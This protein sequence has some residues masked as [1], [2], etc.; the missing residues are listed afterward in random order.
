MLHAVIS[1]VAVAALALQKKPSKFQY[2]PADDQEGVAQGQ[3]SRCLCPATV[4]RLPKAG[5]LAACMRPAKAAAQIAT[6]THG[7]S[8]ILRA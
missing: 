1:V 5:L 2:L 3:D 4:R 8:R 6:G 7:G